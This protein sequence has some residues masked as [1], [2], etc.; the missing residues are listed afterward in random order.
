MTKVCIITGASS[1]IGKATAENML[2]RGY[3]VYGISRRGGDI[4][5]VVSLRADVTDEQEILKAV[6]TVMAESGRIDLFLPI[7]YTERPRCVNIK[8]DNL[9]SSKI[10]GTDVKIL[11]NKQSYIA[12]FGYGGINYDIESENISIDELTDLISTLA[13]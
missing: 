5:N 10:G 8:R 2:K 3:K 1:G 4:D 13:R 11:G 12:F 6:D 7:G 9:I